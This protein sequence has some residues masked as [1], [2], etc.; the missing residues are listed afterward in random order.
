M[1]I[2]L[3][4]VLSVSHFDCFHGTLLNYAEK[5]NAVLSRNSLLILLNLFDIQPY[6]I[7][8]LCSLLSFILVTYFHSFLLHT[9]IFTKNTE[10]ELNLFVNRFFTMNWAKHCNLTADIDIFQNIM[11]S[12]TSKRHISRHISISLNFL[13]PYE[14]RRASIVLYSHMRGQ[15][16]LA[17]YY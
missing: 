5:R 8:L 9:L 12:E 13:V 11:F 4:Y 16:R 6:Q 1:F 3:P 15:S 2:M 17:E 7:V 10:D 14:V